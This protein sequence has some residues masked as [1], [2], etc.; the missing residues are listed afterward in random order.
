MTVESGSELCDR[1]PLDRRAVAEFLPDAGLKWMQAGL[2]AT[3]ETV[4]CPP[5]PSTPGTQRLE[6]LAND[7]VPW[8]CAVVHAEWNAAMPGEVVGGVLLR[9]AE[10]ML[11]VSEASGQS[12]FRNPTNSCLSGLRTAVLVRRGGVSGKEKFVALVEDAADVAAEVA[13]VVI[14]NDSRPMPETLQVVGTSA[15]SVAAVLVSQTD[16]EALRSRLACSD[17]LH[18][19]VRCPGVIVDPEFPAGPKA[20]AAGL[21]GNPLYIADMPSHCIWQKRAGEAPTVFAGIQGVREKVWHDGCPA[22]EATLEYPHDLSVAPS[23]M[24]LYICEIYAVRVVTLASDPPSIATIITSDYGL[25]GTALTDDGRYL[26]V[27]EHSGH[28]IIQIDLSKSLG[29]AN[30]VKVIAGTGDPG[31]LVSGVQARS[32]R[33]NNPTKLKVTITGDIIFL[34][35]GNRSLR[36]IECTSGLIH[37]L[38]DAIDAPDGIAVNPAGAVFVAEGRNHQV[39]QFM[40]AFAGQCVLEAA[41]ADYGGADWHDWD[42]SICVGTGEDMEDVGGETSLDFHECAEGS[43]LHDK[44]ASGHVVRRSCPAL[45]LRL[46]QPQGLAWVPGAGLL[47][48]DSRGRAVHLIHRCTP[49]AWRGQV[50]LL[51]MLVEQGRSTL[52]VEERGAAANNLLRDALSILMCLPDEEFRV[53]LYLW[54]EP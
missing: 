46:C 42:W 19:A 28:R 29:R 1:L 39:L 27:S 48:C 3:A 35:A 32:A 51:R 9:H 49:W 26:F 18:V 54:W 41:A 14:E 24:S 23:G 7:C 17:R 8:S 50:V 44:F 12:R 22:A 15:P 21:E 34:D 10:A 2:N 25:G 43:P 16:G 13:L 45:A 40:P 47:V 4:L 5:P 37:T 36:I 11:D 6:V 38:S 31:P 20:I 30:P 52:R 33:L 53:V